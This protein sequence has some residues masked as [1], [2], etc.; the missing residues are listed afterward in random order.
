MTVSPCAG[1]PAPRELLV[2]LV[3]LECKYYELQPELTDPNQ[4]VAFG[5]SGHPG[6]PHLE[7]NGAE[8]RGLL[9]CLVGILFD[10][11][12]EQVC[13]GNRTLETGDRI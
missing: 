6:S 9:G 13:P 5:M 8:N 3:H 4:L 2:D 1:K 12:V 10:A 7:S 11:F